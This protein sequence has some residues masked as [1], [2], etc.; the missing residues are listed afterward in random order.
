MDMKTFMRKLKGIAK[1]GYGIASENLAPILPNI[2]E[3]T[4][5]NLTQGTLNINLSKAYIVRESIL[6]PK[7]DY[8]QK[9]SIKLQRCKVYGLKYFIMRPS[10]HEQNLKGLMTL[11][12][13]SE[14]C[15]RSK[16]SL[17]DG[18]CLEVEV[19]GDEVCWKGK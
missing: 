5:L 13:M 11:E 9:E 10:G 12:I 3:K 18:D 1:K 7:E 8:N 19:E 6:I 15:L 17:K 16:F 2:R 4:E 14:V